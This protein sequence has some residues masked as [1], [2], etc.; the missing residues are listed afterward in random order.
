[1]RNSIARHVPEDVAVIGAF[2]TIPAHVLAELGTELHC[3]VFVCGDLKTARESVMEAAALIPH[4]RPLDAGPLEMARALER[5]TFLAISLNRRYK[6]RGARFR[7]E[8]I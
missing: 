3:D 6:R 7:I 8:G 1:M 5:M 4:L 2:K